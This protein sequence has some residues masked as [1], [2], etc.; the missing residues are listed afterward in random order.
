MRL[1][2]YFLGVVIAAVVLFFAYTDGGYHSMITFYVAAS[3]ST[4]VVLS[5]LALVVTRF[6]TSKGRKARVFFG[7]GTVLLFGYLPS[8]RAIVRLFY[9]PHGLDRMPIDQELFFYAPMIVSALC[10][11]RGILL[12]ADESL[13]R[14]EP[15]NSPEA[16]PGQHRPAAPSPSSGAPHL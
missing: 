4:Y 12:W 8:L 15:N 3:A 5:S 6:G 1:I 10:I 2:P 13:T 16:T 11:Y 7:S 9:V 14:E